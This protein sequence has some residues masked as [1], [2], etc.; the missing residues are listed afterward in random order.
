MTDPRPGVGWLARLTAGSSGGSPPG[1][2][3]P[4]TPGIGRP[5]AGTAPGPDPASGTPTRAPAGTTGPEGTGGTAAAG[6]RAH[7]RVTD[8]VVERTL[9]HLELTVLRRLDGLLLGDYLGILPGQGSEKAE[10][11]E[12]QFGDDVR[13]MDWA[14]TARTTVPHVHDLIAD[15]ELETWALVD[16]TASQSFGSA[17]CEKR[18][19][20]IAATAAVGFLTA[21][22]GNRMGAIALTD[23]GTRLIPARPGRAG[24][25]ALLRTLLTIEP[26]AIPPGRGTLGR[27]A[28]DAAPATRPARASRF[29][30]QP[31]GPAHQ[32]ASPARRAAAPG[33]RRTG[34]NLAEA[35][36][37]LRRPVRRRGLVVVVSDFLSVDLSWARPLRALAGRHDMLAVEVVDPLELALPNVGPLAV[38]DPETG[39]LFDLPTHSRRFRERY[40]AAAASH[41]DDVA[42]ALRGAGAAHLRLR[43]DTDWLIEIARY[44]A[45]NRRGQA[46]LRGAGGGA[47][48][49]GGTARTRAVKEAANQRRPAATVRPI[50]TG[51]TTT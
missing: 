40:E 6:G 48:G 31:A 39:E 22:T 46:A 23:A 32:Q 16:L 43:T 21:R 18:E 7:V 15:R 28:P 50:R 49:G 12:Y 14:V 41:R 38:V 1:G 34:T 29:A 19:L 24:L 45:A 35:I 37:A 5:W 13:R 26:S 8:P 3:S 51:D 25:R 33:S 11:R 10:S 30:G 4:P 17:R 47:R 36:E 44:A 27:R 20:A 9:R 42:A 2:G